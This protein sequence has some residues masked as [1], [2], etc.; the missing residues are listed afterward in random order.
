MPRKILFLLVLIS[1]GSPVLL[2]QAQQPASLP[3]D[4]SVVRIKTELVQTDV[5]IFDRHGHF[6][7]GLRPEDFALT[8]DG[9]Q[10]NIQF[11]ERVAAG[12]AQEENQLSAVRLAMPARGR[13]AD[14]NSDDVDRVRTIFFF[15]DDTHLQD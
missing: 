15:V 3:K 5:M 10:Q 14:A 11:F 7:D 6:V 1:F 9:K 4:D 2:I 12:S 8:L 13:K